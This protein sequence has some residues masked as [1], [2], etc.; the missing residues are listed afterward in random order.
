MTK[1]YEAYAVYENGDKDQYTGLT[2]R[3]A[4]WRYHWFNRHSAKLG[5]KIVGWRL[6]A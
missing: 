1:T 2:K 5:L 4:L 6:E 3:R